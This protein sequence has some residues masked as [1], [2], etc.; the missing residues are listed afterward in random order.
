MVKRWA[1]GDMKKASFISCNKCFSTLLMEE[2]LHCAIAK[3]ESEKK[4]KE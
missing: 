2:A 1:S 3:K 4:K